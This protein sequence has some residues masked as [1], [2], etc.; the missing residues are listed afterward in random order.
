M[1][2]A[3]RSHVGIV[4]TSFAL[5]LGSLLAAG[6]SGKQEGPKTTGPGKTTGTGLDT[7]PAA[8]TAAADDALP[9]PAYESALPEAVRAELNES[10]KGDLDEMVK[11]RLVRVGVTY[12]RTIYFVDQGVQRGVAYEY[13]KLME[14][15]LNKRRKTGNLKVVFWCVPLPRDQLLPALLDGRVDMVI[16]RGHRYSRTPQERGLHESD[17]QERGPGRRDRPRRAGDR[18]GRRPVRAGGVRPQ[19]QRVSTRACWL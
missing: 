7:Q 14:D 13:A 19:E 17:A 10:F 16:A 1:R 12:N 2:H 15:E 8:P 3:T 11:R 5:L 6:C 18:V 9:T 4:A